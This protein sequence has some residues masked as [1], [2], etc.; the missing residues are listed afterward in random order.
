MAESLKNKTVRGVGWSFVESFMAQGISFL[1]GLVLARMLTPDEYGLIGIITI[2]ITVLNSFVDSGFSNAL[3]RKQHVTQEDYNTVFVTNI[4]FSILMVILL[5]VAAPLI[6]RFFKRTELVSLTRVMGL[7]VIFNALSLVQNT[8]LTK[9]LDFKTKT[10]AS[11]ISAIISGIIGICMAFM[12]YGVWSL[13]GQALSRQLINS[14]CLWFFNRW[15]PNFSF[16]WESFKEMWSFGWKLLVSKLIDTTWN[17]LYQVVVGK[18]YSP[19]TLG[20]YTRGKQFASLFSQNLTAVVQRVSYPALSEIQNDRVRLVQA[21]RRVI[22]ITMFVTDV[23]MLFLAAIS[24]PLLFCLI[25]PQWHQASVFLPLI[26]ITMS[27]YPLHA[28]NLNML[29]VQGRSDLFLKL[30]IIKKVLAVVPLLLG[31][32]VS[33]FWMLAGSIVTGVISFFFNSYY[34]GKLLNYSSWM[35][36]RDISNSYFIAALV[37][38]SVYFFKFLPLSYFVILP[39]QLVFGAL[40]FFI[41]CR[42]TRCEEYEEVLSISKGYFHLIYK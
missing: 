38:L 21:Y 29:Q 36:L 23:L 25:G 14:I 12:G 18:F 42:I 34:S 40:V 26:C 7:V 6:A 4:V 1:V 32:F 39:L 9:K 31:I 15:W 3:I 8:I 13:V 16:Y 28:I 11:L 22:K 33:I 2:F 17:E 19:A 24:E 41:I 30:E 10:K 5:Y 37:A 35:Q 20:Q 27:L